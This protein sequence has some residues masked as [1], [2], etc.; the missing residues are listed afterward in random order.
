L[1]LLY[2]NKDDDFI[3]FCS[4]VRKELTT[5]TS[6]IAIKTPNEIA[7]KNYE[8]PKSELMSIDQVLDLF[9]QSD[10]PT[11][12]KLS[13][14]ILNLLG[15]SVESN[16]DS[17]KIHD[18]QL[19]CNDGS[20][21]LVVG[22]KA[23][24]MPSSGDVITISALAKKENAKG[25]IITNQKA[26]ADIIEKSV[27]ED[28]M[29]WGFDK[30]HDILL[31]LPT[32]PSSEYYIVLLKEGKF[33]GFFGIIKSFDFINKRAF[34]NLLNYPD[35]PVLACDIGHL[36]PLTL[37][38]GSESYERF[39]KEYTEFVDSNESTIGKIREITSDS[40]YI[41][42][43]QIRKVS[44]LILKEHD[45]CIRISAKT[46]GFTVRLET[47]DEEIDKISCDCFYWSDRSSERN[48]CRHIAAVIL[49]LDNHVKDKLL[50]ILT[51][52]NT[53]KQTF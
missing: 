49:R 5:E 23:Y 40:E 1:K 2:Y 47:S 20:I 18:T 25:L 9:I 39:A 4:S 37:S 26:S 31:G 42:V 17:N 19:K 11:I 14:L 38:P 13:A 30:I 41:A 52:W 33:K 35:H 36:E 51:K 24:E 43:F 29:I 15:F 53:D 8:M 34:V 48:I 21:T 12:I 32:L 10:K 28:I 3:Y 16:S 7:K 6:G 44:D 50:E 46:E 22:I 45:G 27:S